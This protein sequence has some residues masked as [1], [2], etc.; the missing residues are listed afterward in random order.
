MTGQAH[1]AAREKAGIAQATLARKMGRH[2]SSVQRLERRAHVGPAVSAR[3]F[4]AL[5]ECVEEERLIRLRA[6]RKLVELAK[7]GAALAVTA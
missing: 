4:A 6:G 5:Q 2:Q 7:Q 3:Y 1:E